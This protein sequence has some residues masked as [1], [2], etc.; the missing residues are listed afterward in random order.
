MDTAIETRTYG[1]SAGEFRL[2]EDVR[3][4]LGARAAAEVEC[5]LSR[6]I[7]R[8][9]NLTP[10]ETKIVRGFAVARGVTLPE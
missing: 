9:H 10:D 5:L 3:G 1:F 2:V 8:F 4:H 7:R 6:Q